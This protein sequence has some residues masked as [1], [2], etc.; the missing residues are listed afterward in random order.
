[1]AQSGALGGKTYSLGMTRVQA[2]VSGMLADCNLPVDK[3]TANPE[4]MTP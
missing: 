2:S 1:M 4:K 3:L